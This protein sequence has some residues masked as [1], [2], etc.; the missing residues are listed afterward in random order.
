[1]S[2]REE[3]AGESGTEEVAGTSG[4][5]EVA[6]PSCS[7]RCQVPPIRPPTTRARRDMRV[8]EAALALIR[9]T[10]HPPAANHS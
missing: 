5:E 9:G 8:S 10:G 6:G 1:M 2:G 7:T 3:G 4:T